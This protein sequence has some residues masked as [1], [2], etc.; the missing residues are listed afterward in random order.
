MSRQIV[1][2]L[3]KAKKVSGQYLNVN[4]SPVIIWVIKQIPDKEPKFH[5]KEMLVGVGRSIKELLIIFNKG[6]D[7]INWIE[8]IEIKFLSEGGLC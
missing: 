6:W 4:K 2:T 5:H 1:L 8:W 3:S 7:F